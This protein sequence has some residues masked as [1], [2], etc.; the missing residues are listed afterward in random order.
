MQ[1][2]ILLCIGVSIL[3]G[4]VSGWFGLCASGVC[5]VPETYTAFEFDAILKNNPF[6]A[7]YLTNGANDMASRQAINTVAIQRA[8]Q[9]RF[10]V[11]NGQCLLDAVKKCGG[12]TA[13]SF[14]FFT[15]GQRASE[16]SFAAGGDIE[17]RLNSG[18]TDLVTLREPGRHAESVYSD[19]NE[20]Y[21]DDDDD[22]T[23]Y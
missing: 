20:L 16:L 5:F 14:H 3:C 4:V 22:V 10:V 2:R 12:S 19:E 17:Q 23:S 8:G 7:V 21:E 13:P 11:V 1:A 6:V 15:R 18:L 9:A